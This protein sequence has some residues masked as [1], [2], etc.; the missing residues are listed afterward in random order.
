MTTIRRCNG[1]GHESSSYVLPSGWDMRS[2]Y[3]TRNG[4]RK[5][6][7]FLHLCVPCLKAGR[8]FVNGEIV[9]PPASG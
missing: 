1:C 3:E 4:K 6:V 2:T 8:R 7:D 5:F 9:E